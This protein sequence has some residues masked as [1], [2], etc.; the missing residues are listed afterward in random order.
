MLDNHV[1]FLHDVRF[2]LSPTTVEQFREPSDKCTK[3]SPMYFIHRWMHHVS[4]Q[5]NAPAPMMHIHDATHPVHESLFEDEELSVLAYSALE[6]VRG[7]KLCVF[8]MLFLHIPLKVPLNNS[9]RRNCYVK[10]NIGR[11]S[12]IIFSKGRD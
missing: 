10:S 1:C 5:C 12:T 8:Y 6:I 9:D 4:L 7:W 2:H 3:N 11:V